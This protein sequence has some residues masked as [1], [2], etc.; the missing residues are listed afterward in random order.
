MAQKQPKETDDGADGEWPG[1]DAWK[2]QTK[3]VERIITVTLTLDEPQTAGWIAEE[4][5]LSESAARDHLDMLTELGVVSATTAHNVTKYS[6]DSAYLR[7]REVAQLV[8][9]HDRD[10]LMDFVAD[11]KE[12]VEDLQAEYGVESPDDLRQEVVREDLGADEI[13]EYK[14]V[15]SEWESILHELSIAD[16]AL[17]RYDEYSSGGQQITA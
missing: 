8:E 7:F 12:E 15:A 10:E 5:H 14:K 13:R 4:A 17:E 9:M 11:R 3:G 6:P 16:E 1:E 2:E